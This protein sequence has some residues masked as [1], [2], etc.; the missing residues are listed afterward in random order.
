MEE[1]KAIWQPWA[2]WAKDNLGFNDVGFLKADT[3]DD[4][5]LIVMSAV[6]QQS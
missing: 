6:K 5:A 1:P 3:N 2:E 4:I